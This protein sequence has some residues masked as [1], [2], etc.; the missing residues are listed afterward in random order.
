M[1]TVNILVEIVGGIV[2]VSEIVAPPGLKVRVT[3]RDYDTGDVDPEDLESFD[4]DENG[5]E[6]FVSLVEYPEPA[7][8]PGFVW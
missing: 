7:E 6:C 8:Q 4:T 2:N 3:I 1:E 5:R